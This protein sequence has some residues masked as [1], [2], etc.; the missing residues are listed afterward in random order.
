MSSNPR[1]KRPPLLPTSKPSLSHQR[2]QLTE[3]PPNTRYADHERHPQYA[4]DS[5]NAA[6]HGQRSAGASS[7]TT[8]VD[9]AD[10][11]ILHSGSSRGRDAVTEFSN[12]MDQR[13]LLSSLKS[14]YGSVTGSSRSST[15]RSKQS[16]RSQQSAAAAQA[17][18]EALDELTA[19]GEIESR[20]ERNL[21]KLTGQ[22][23]PTPSNG[24]CMTRV[25]QQRC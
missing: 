16:G 10:V 2:P 7:V 3:L 18:L 8:P 6:Q 23:P 20:S 24:K 19:R 13:I 9:S 12:V 17:R 11:H 4:Q 1:G 22:V 21:F 25:L 14:D 5:S 15:A